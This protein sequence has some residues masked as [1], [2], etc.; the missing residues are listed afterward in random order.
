[1]RIDEVHTE[2]KRVGSPVPTPGAAYEPRVNGAANSL[3]RHSR[4]SSILALQDGFRVATAVERLSAPVEWTAPTDPRSRWHGQQ[5]TCPD[6]R[7]P[8]RW[9]PSA[10]RKLSPS[11][12]ALRWRALHIVSE[13]E[14]V[15]WQTQPARLW[16]SCRSGLSRP[17]IQRCA[18]KAE[19]RK[20][21][22]P[23]STT[24]KHASRRHS[25]DAPGQPACLPFVCPK[26]F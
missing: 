11:R 18:Q 2:E 25:R 3:P 5:P 24:K 19:P 13:V 8:S 14:R 26:L 22:K 1:M 23:L 4:D 7:L 6:R 9:S 16:I 15:A 21:P 17:D 10:C 12:Q 20:V